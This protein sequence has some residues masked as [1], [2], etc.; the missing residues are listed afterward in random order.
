[1]MGNGG[2]NFRDQAGQVAQGVWDLFVRQKLPEGV[3]RAIKPCDRCQGQ[4]QIQ[5]KGVLMPCPVCCDEE[6]RMR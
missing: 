2:G 3:K 4:R 1:M 6:G 5:W